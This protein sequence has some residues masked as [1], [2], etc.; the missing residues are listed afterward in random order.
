MTDRRLRHLAGLLRPYRGRVILMLVALASNSGIGPALFALAVER[1]RVVKFG[2]SAPELDRQKAT[3]LRTME[4]AIAEREHQPSSALA[5]SRKMRLPSAP[6]IS[7][8]ALSLASVS[9]CSGVFERLRRVQVAFASGASKVIK[10][11]YGL[12]RQKYVYRPRR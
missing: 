1:E 7:T 12:D 5:A 11:G 4:R 8:N 2:F 6:A 3:L 10:N 9:A